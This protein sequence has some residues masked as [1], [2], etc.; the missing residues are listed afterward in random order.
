MKAEDTS[1]C[2]VMTFMISG[3]LLPHVF[4]TARKANRLLPHAV[5]HKKLSGD[6][7]TRPV[8][9]KTFIKNQTG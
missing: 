6:K 8:M 1:T 4:I 7:S 5:I 2:C 9:E 3:M